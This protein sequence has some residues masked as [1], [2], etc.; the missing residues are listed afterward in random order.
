ML[1][2]SLNPSLSWVPDWASYD[3]RNDIPA[4]WPR[5]C[6]YFAVQDLPQGNEGLTISGINTGT[7]KDVWPLYQG[8]AHTVYTGSM[9]DIW[10]DGIKAMH[11]QNQLTPAEEE[12]RVAAFC[13]N[14]YFGEEGSSLNLSDTKIELEQEDL[15]GFNLRGIL[16]EETALRSMHRRFFVTDDGSMGIGPNTIQPGDRVTALLGSA[17]PFVIAPC[18]KTALRVQPDQ[19]Y[20]RL[21]GGCYVDGAMALEPFLGSLPDGRKTFWKDSQIYLEDSKTPGYGIKDPRLERLAS[22]EG[23]REWLQRGQPKPLIST[24]PEQWQSIGVNVERFTLL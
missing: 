1:K 16:A 12:R 17:M 11:I 14:L 7:I 10:R 20:Y 22:F 13:R 23:Y 15:N 18:D 21:R 8:G 3:K 6:N 2:L 9:I 4:T 19:S 24:T 5:F